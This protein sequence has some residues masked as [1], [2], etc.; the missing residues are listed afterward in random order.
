MEELFPLDPVIPS[1]KH[2]LCISLLSAP[3]V[4]KKCDAS[5]P[6]W[7]EGHARIP[8]PLHPPLAPTLRCGV[9]YACLTPL[10][11][12]YTPSLLAT[13]EHAPS[14]LQTDKYYIYCMNIYS[15][16]NGH[17]NGHFLLS[18]SFNLFYLFILVMRNNIM[19]CGLFP[20]S[21]VELSFAVWYLWKHTHSHAYTNKMQ[22]SNMRC[23]F[24]GERDIAVGSKSKVK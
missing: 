16:F 12:M 10:T 2:T 18:Y 1:F 14:W 4:L 20:S 11:L 24:L 3:P 5:F 23:S 22:A 17:F 6:G 15:D 19:F 8:L 13:T 21:F 7:Q 9:L